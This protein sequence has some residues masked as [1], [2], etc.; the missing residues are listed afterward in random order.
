MGSTTIAIKSAMLAASAVALIAC[1]FVT[2]KPAPSKS[3]APVVR[4][5]KH[6]AWSPIPPRASTATASA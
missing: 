5:Y 2:K 3:T 1:T 6:A 4:I